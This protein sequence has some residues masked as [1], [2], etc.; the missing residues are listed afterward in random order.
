MVISHLSYGLILWGHAANCKE[1]LKLQNSTV[2]IMTS[3]EDLNHYR[4]RPVQLGLISL[5]LKYNPG[6]FTARED[7]HSYTRG[8]L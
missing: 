3:K 2:S 1:V 6:K 4:L 5:E 7:V 8:E